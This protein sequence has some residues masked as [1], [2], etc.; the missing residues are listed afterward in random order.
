MTFPLLAAFDFGSNIIDKI[1]PDPIERDKAKLKLLELKQSGELA[2]LT[3]NSEIAKMQLEVN[4]VEAGNR[5][6]F[7]S[8]WRPFVG[9]T[10]ATALFYHFM[11]RVIILDI[12]TA[13]G[14]N[15]VLTE[16][17]MQSLSTILMSMLGL[18]GLRTYEKF[19]GVSK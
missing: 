6:I 19:K 1:W 8:G 7:V 15:I 13:L 2:E 18:G 4:K 5:N 14:L 12:C 3:A 9:W 16:F 10:C 11:L 17:D